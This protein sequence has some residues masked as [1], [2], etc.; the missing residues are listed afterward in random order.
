MN[1]GYTAD[2]AAADLDGAIEAGTLSRPGDRPRPFTRRSGWRS[3][4]CSPAELYR[5]LI[6]SDTTAW[7]SRPE[8]GCPKNLIGPVFDRSIGR[9]GAG[10]DVPRTRD[11][12]DR[13]RR[14]R[15]NGRRVV[16]APGDGRSVALKALGLSSSPAIRSLFGI[17]GG[18][19]LPRDGDRRRVRRTV[20]CPG[21]DTRSGELPNADLVVIDGGY[22]A[23]LTHSDEWRRAVEAHLDAATADNQL[24]GG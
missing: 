16:R 19:Q 5:S 4:H 14:P 8:N 11:E 3:A 18:D 17:A 20:R 21:T 15:P 12:P 13:S 23:M 10:P 6:L 9:R 2:P 1:S 22:D 7:S 24:H